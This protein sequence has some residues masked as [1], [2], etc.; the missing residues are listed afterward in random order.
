[1]RDTALRA[2][3]LPQGAV[4]TLADGPLLLGALEVARLLGIGRTKVYE[5][6]VR[7]ELPIVRIGRCVRVSRSHLAV[8][9]ESRTAK[10][11][12]LDAED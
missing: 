3:S 1:M 10:P 12:E 5:L 8:W 11:L 2:P 4:D 6:I 7:G 9:I